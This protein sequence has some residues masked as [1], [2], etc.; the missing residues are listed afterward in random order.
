MPR[1]AFTTHLRRH[2]DLGGSDIEV[3]G[4]TVREVLEAVFRTR[5]R[6]RGYVLEDTGALR[7]H[8]VI[9]IDNDQIQDRDRLGD[10]VPAGAT[11][12]VLQAL[13]GGR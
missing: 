11:V 9:F 4:A 3:S 13:S 10:P 5:P 12:H 2:L 1:V 7:R 6:L 8:M